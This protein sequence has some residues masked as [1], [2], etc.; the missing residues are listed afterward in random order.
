MLRLTG[1]VGSVGSAARATPAPSAKATAAMPPANTR[2]RERVSA[3]IGSFPVLPGMPGSCVFNH[4]QPATRRT[5][6]TPPH[7]TKIAKPVNLNY[8]FLSPRC[9]PAQTTPIF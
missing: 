1:F 7:M 8:H 2:L 5:G 4:R 9:A 3:I 6:A